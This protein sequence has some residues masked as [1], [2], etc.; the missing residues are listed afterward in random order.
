[1]SKYRTILIVE[2]CNFTRNMLNNIAK[3][4]K[5]E[6]KCKFVGGAK[7]VYLHRELTSAEEHGP[8]TLPA[9][10]NLVVC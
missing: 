10:I 8:R 6:R 1:M 9:K 4:D 7:A 2:F 3:T 5:T